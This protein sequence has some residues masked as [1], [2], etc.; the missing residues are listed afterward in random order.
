[1]NADGTLEKAPDAVPSGEVAD[2]DQTQCYWSPMD[3]CYHVLGE[4]EKLL[5]A[6][7]GAKLAASQ[8]LNQE[9]DEVPTPILVSLLVCRF[10]LLRVCPPLLRMLLVLM[11]AAFRYAD[12]RGALQN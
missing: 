1:M 8:V 3:G 6:K 7:A 9:S 10:A 12:S 11:C 2:S 4:E 5:A